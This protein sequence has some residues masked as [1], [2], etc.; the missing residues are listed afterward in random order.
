MI[1]IV[2]VSVGRSDVSLYL[3]IWRA[4]AA[5]PQLSLDVILAG[6][7]AAAARSSLPM[8]IAREFRIANHAFAPL[9][10]DAPVDIARAMGRATIEFANAYERLRPDWLLVLGDR[11]EM[12]AAALAAIPLR[13]ATA[14]VH[15]GEVTHG[16]IDEAFRHAITKY[17]HLHFVST[18]DHRRRVI[19]LGEEP[20]RVTVSGAPALDNLQTIDWATK[21]ELES[22]LCLD[23]S[24][25]PLLV[26]YHPETLHYERAVE[27]TDRLLS[28]LAD[29]T[30]PVLISQ[31]NADT[32]RQGV[33][34]RLAAFGHGRKNV[35]LH[36]SLGPR[37]WYSLMKIAAAMVGNSSSGII[38]AAS[39]E[40]PVVNIGLRQAGRCRSKNV[41]DA[42]GDTD[43]I[44]RSLEW[45]VSP[46]FRGSLAGLENAFGDGRAAQRIVDKLLDTRLDERLYVKRFHDLIGS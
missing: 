19:Q 22:L 13:L 16:A 36:E 7:H 45:A 46:E 11:Y 42:A 37:V 29:V 28:A 15:G 18:E 32:G 26:T 9:E 41:I 1:K 5:E 2:A 27:Q 4:I 33:A 8:E 43:A 38:E 23:L 31:P 6:E 24:E 35:R 21:D 44:R 12:H 17:S 34:A 39:F 25:A 3:P 10:G 20:W 14:H 30:R 40:L